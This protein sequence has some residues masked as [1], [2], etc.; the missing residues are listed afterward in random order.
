[1]YSLF[2]STASA[3]I[4]ASEMEDGG[5]NFGAVRPESCVFKEESL[6]SAPSIASPLL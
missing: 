3:A 1:M 5:F 2:G 6:F 4:T